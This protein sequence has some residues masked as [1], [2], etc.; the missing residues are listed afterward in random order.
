MFFF[1]AIFQTL[2]ALAVRPVAQD[3]VVSW[4]V[5]PGESAVC[6]LCTLKQLVSEY[7]GQA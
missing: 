4:E 6:H 7:P 1:E 5:S 3:L 2:Q